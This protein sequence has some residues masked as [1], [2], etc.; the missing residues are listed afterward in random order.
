MK[1]KVL[2]LL[3]ILAVMSCSDTNSEQ[4]KVVAPKKDKATSETLPNSGSY[5]VTIDP[6]ETPFNTEQY[7]HI[8]ENDFHAAV[9]KPL[10]T[11]GID[12]DGASYSNTRRFL[13]SN[14]MPPKDAVRI[15]EFVNY[16]NYEYEQPKG[17]HPFAVATEISECPWNTDHRLVHIG[18][19][20]ED[21]PMTKVPA[22]NLVFLIDVSGSMDQ[23][24][25]LPLLKQSLKMLIKEIRDKDRIAMVVYAGATGVVLESMPGSKRRVMRNALA[26]LKAGG[27]TA[28]AAG[29]QLAYGIAQ[30]N[31][32]KG[33]NNRVI[34]ATD[35]DFNVGVSSDSELVQIIEKERKK[36]VFL[37]VLG[38]GTGNLKD[39][40]MEKIA[41][42][43]NGNYYYIDNVK[44]A[45]KVLV[46]EITRTIYTIAKDVKLQVEFNPTH[47]KEYRL[48][49]YEN[50][51][52]KDE[53]FNNDL[54]DS[55]D[56][57]AGHTVTALY[58]V[59]P[60]VSEGS[61]TTGSVDPLKYQDRNVKS[62]AG[63]DPDLMTI[64]IR[65]KDP[66]SETSKLFDLTARDNGLKLE[67]A[68]DNFKF[69][70]AVAGFGM[71]LRNS[72][73]KGGATYDSMEELAIQSKGKDEKGYRDEFIRLID[74]AR[75][76]G[77]DQSL[78]AEK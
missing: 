17:E 10:S 52:L 7:D 51:V 46:D 64:K 40:K 31:Y 76:F 55:G 47:V 73:Y 70:A 63:N 14:R 33:G 74:L 34:L 77:G 62:S 44:E 25:K 72:S 38:F 6:S 41:D 71:L 30:K 59:V 36:G 24:D 4:F 16:F 8:V 23:P 43:G 78:E 49:G 15:E 61:M 3:M 54:K 13:T 45:K 9:N 1:F 11:F 50:R 39:S 53:D 12:V 57:G 5:T 18:L 75:S 26:E 58:E 28:G 22:S 21:V 65:Y 37:S 20:A 48:I 66:E 19:K 32:I 69:S 56:M 42:N 35:G 27:G 60:A 29:I 2:S 68:S 67:D